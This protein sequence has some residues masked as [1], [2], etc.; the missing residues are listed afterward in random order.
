MSSTFKQEIRNY[1][2]NTFLFGRGGDDVGDAESLLDKGIIDST[3]VLELVSFLEEK[4]GVQVTD[5]ELTANN[6]DSIDRLTAFV[7]SKRG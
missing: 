2:V 5:D 6:F 3:G 1:I 7:N 4:Y